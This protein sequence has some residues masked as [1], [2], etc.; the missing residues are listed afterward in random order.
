[1]IFINIYLKY[2]IYSIFYRI[3]WPSY[4]FNS[5]KLAAVNSTNLKCILKNFKLVAPNQSLFFGLK[6]LPNELMLSWCENNVIDCRAPLAHSHLTK[7][8][9]NKG[10]VDFQ[11][12]NN[13]LG[14]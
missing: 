3:S 14:Q 6:K 12:T 1:L 13:C 7:K 2:L 5:N 10:G 9:E 4:R 11:E 8:P